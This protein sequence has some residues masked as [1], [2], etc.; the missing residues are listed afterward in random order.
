MLLVISVISAVIG[1]VTNPKGDLAILVV[2][3]I[4]VAAFMVVYMIALLISGKW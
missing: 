1:I 4:V 2:F 3:A